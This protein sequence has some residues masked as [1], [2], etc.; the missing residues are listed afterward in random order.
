MT[1]PVGSR[2]ELAVQNAWKVVLCFPGT[3]RT[4]GSQPAQV[5][6]ASQILAVDIE[7]A[8]GVQITRHG[9]EVPGLCPDVTLGRAQQIVVGEPVQLVR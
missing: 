7:V 2:V 6:R 5:A 9:K 1:V 3:N 4:C 8:I